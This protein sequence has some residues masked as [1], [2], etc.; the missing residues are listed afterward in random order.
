MVIIYWTYPLEV[1]TNSV[2]FMNEILN[3]LDSE[4]SK[5]VSNYG[6][7]VEWNA[8]TIDFTVSSFVD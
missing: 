5:R 4:G 6:V 8:L 3:W 2:D 7:V 1:G